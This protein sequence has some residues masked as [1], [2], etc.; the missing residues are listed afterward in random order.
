MFNLNAL[1]QKCVVTFS[2]I[3]PFNKI[4]ILHALLAVSMPIILLVNRLRHFPPF[5]IEFQVPHQT[6][7]TIGTHVTCLT[8]CTL[9]QQ[10]E[11]ADLL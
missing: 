4:E 2:D 1:G 11:R 5:R 6:N 3:S 7:T 10:V 8:H 9:I